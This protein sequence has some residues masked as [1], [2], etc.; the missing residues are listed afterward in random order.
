MLW[1]EYAYKVGDET[2]Y[3]FNDNKPLYPDYVTFHHEIEQ[4]EEEYVETGETGSKADDSGIIGKRVTQ[5][6]SG[7]PEGN[8]PSKSEQS[9]Q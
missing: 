8:D 7:P 5:D 2:V 3:E 9:F 4:E 1:I 6:P